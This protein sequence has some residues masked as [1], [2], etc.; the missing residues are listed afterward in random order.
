VP[1][2]SFLRRHADELAFVGREPAS[3][4]LEQALAESRQRH[5]VFVSGEPGVGKTRLVAEFVE[6]AASDGAT[7]LGSAFEQGGDHSWRVLFAGLRELAVHHEPPSSH[8]PL[9]SAVVPGLASASAVS[10]AEVEPFSISEAVGAWLVAVGEGGPVVWVVDDLHW[11]DE[12]VLQVLR[13]LVPVLGDSPVLVVGT[14]RDS[15]LDRSHPLAGWLA[16]LRRHELPQ[17]ID[18]HGLTAEDTIA[19]LAARATEPLD[20]SMLR[21]ADEIYRETEGNAFFIGQ[22]IDHLVETSA[23]ELLDGQWSVTAEYERLGL[24]Q[25]VREV[26]GRRL[27]QL[28]AGVD[29]VLAVAAVQGREFSVAVACAAL[30]ATVDRVADAFD[31]A[32]RAGLIRADAGVSG[33][34]RFVHALV[35]QTL[36][37]ELSSL[38][39]SR[40]HFS[41]ASALAD[42]HGS[43]SPD[44]TVR[45]AGHF[46]EAAAVGGLPQ[47]VDFL[48]QPGA[49]E[50]PAALDLALRALAD[51]DD[52]GLDDRRRVL[53]HMLVA[54]AAWIARND[55]E[56]TNRSFS[57]AVRI[58]DVLGDPELFANAVASGANAA[59]FGSSFEFLAL[60][61]RALEGVDP[62]IACRLPAARCDVVLEW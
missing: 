57:E 23:L 59:G 62:A 7:V 43:L 12:P 50:S 40:L 29:E 55:R 9:L 36:L 46:L 30:D 28:P 20:A 54:E 37:D 48:S 2:P 60:A 10:V 3:A 14:Y 15:D 27:A 8:R 34:F 41:I 56:L 17:R 45:I 25:G 31:A 39:R 53:L 35:R 32:E 11:A 38:R 24:P 6:H 49:R 47:A 44:A 18:L 21:L 52:V 51:A 1:V 33:R 26:V 61:P 4:Q 58:A 16:D 22:V 5:L 42:R 19:V 13:N